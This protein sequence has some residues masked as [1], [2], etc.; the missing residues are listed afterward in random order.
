M[1]QKEISEAY[2]GLFNLMMNEHNLILTIS[3]MDD[4]IHESQKVV[5]DYDA[6]MLETNFCPKCGSIRI[7]RIG[8]RE[9]QC[10]SC[11]LSWYEWNKS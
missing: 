11:R 6:I 3:E 5:E 9:Y 2:Q 10:L 1:E 4:I 7:T 8:G